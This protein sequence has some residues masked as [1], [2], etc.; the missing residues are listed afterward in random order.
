MP[1][2]DAQC[3]TTQ[4]TTVSPI[5]QE[6]MRMKNYPTTTNLEM[7]N[8]GG[9]SALFKQLFQCWR[10]KEQTVGLGKTHTVGKVGKCGAQT[11]APFPNPN[12]FWRFNYLMRPNTWRDIRCRKNTDCNYISLREKINIDFIFLPYCYHRLY[13]VRVPETP[14]PEPTAVALVC[15]FQQD[16]EMSIKNEAWILPLVLGTILSRIYLCVISV[17]AE[18]SQDS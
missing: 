14:A 2:S 10:V 15:I 7:V 12:Q 6:F 1:C 18:G 5:V 3:S 8:D 13:F 9:E 11:P 16:Q 17:L 4:L